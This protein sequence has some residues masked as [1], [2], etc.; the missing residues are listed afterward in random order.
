M[1]SAGLGCNGP[2]GPALSTF[3][4]IAELWGPVGG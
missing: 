1:G 2:S 3:F 4:R